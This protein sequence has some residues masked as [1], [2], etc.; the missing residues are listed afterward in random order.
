[1]QRTWIKICGI[2]RVEDALAAA[3]AGVDA[4]G[5]VFAESPRRIAAEDARTIIRDLPPHVL[6]F[7]VFVDETPAEVSRVVAASEVDRVQIHGFEEPMVRELVGTRV[8]KAFRARD[9]SV[10]EEI[11]ESATD[12]F[13]LDTWRQHAAGGTGETF[14]W[15]IARQATELGRVVLAGGLNS[16]NVGEAIRTVRPFGVDV[17]SGVEEGPGIKDAEK[18]RRFVE[19]VRA[20]DRELSRESA[21]AS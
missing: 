14:D 19:A 16:G 8:V 4:L 5:F 10:L 17:S 13:L 6:R 7:G 20:A 1:M 2:T 3:E 9:G 12:F 18:I 15:E 21:G 11:R